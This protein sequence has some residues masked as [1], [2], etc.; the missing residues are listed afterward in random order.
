MF[1]LD[2][3][4]LDDTHLLNTIVRIVNRVGRRIDYGNPHVDARLPD[5][6]RVHAIIPP[7]AIDGC[8]LTI[9]KFRQERVQLE[10]LISWG[11]LTP[12]MAYFLGAGVKARL[13][14]M[15]AGGTGT[16]KTTFLNI[17][18]TLIPGNQRIVTIEDSAELRLHETHPHVIRL[19][20]RATNT[21]GRGEVT[22]RD[23]MRDSLRM[24]PDRI[25]VGECRGSE[26]V[27]MLQA[28]NTGHD[29]SMSTAH[30]NAAQD[31]LMRLET[32]FLMGSVNLP[33]VAI[34]RQIASALDIIVHLRRYA[35]GTRRVAEICE[36]LG[37]GSDGEINI[38]PLF[39]YEVSDRDASG[40]V[41]GEFRVTDQAPH[42]LYKFDAEGMIFP[43]E[44]FTGGVSAL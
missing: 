13:N 25:I 12:D 8:V 16:G 14:I 11:A 22:I 27:D 37:V 17:L 20:T 21:E 43:A 28:M 26:V 31:L 24:R 18:S 3:K 35:D 29:G 15:V 33:A 34:R 39:W 2:V 42:F 44:I 7:L 41:I 32:M 30:A 4:F 6:S 19:E 36:V 40:K 38:R 1:R 5:G 23:L 10:D 9:R